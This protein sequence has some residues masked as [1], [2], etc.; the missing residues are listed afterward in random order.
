MKRTRNGP[1]V[2]KKTNH[3]RVAWIHLIVRK[4][5]ELYASQ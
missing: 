4:Q 1:L 2:K 5:N 3:T